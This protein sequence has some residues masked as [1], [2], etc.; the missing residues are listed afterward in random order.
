MSEPL[1][2]PQ[3]AQPH[4]RYSAVAVGLHWVIA[5]TIAIQ[6]GIGWYMGDMEA[7]SP[8]KREMEAIHISLGLTIPLLTVMRIIWRLIHRP[9]P[10]ALPQASWERRLSLAVH[11]LFYVLL[12][13]LPLTGWIMESVGPRPIPFWGVVWPHFPGL[14]AMLQGRDGGAFKEALEGL[15]SSPLVWSMIALVALHVVGA[16][17]HQF[18][19]S[20]VLWR[21]IPLLKRPS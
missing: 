7:R 4:L 19:G 6:I 17:K 9:P 3:G 16:L 15:H 1:A 5:A 2:P 13:A 8:A 18:D 20:P 12:L 14:G 21:M 10:V 11:A